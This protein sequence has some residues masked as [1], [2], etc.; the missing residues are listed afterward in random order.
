M[1]E[2]GNL[3][4]MMIEV[5]IGLTSLRGRTRGGQN[6]LRGDFTT[7]ISIFNESDDIFYNKNEHGLFV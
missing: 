4:Y 2:A 1:A 7:S 3:V 6:G 5:M